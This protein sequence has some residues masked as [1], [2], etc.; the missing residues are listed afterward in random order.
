MQI[1]ILTALNEGSN[2]FNPTKSGGAEFGATKG[3]KTE[4]K[5]GILMK[6]QNWWSC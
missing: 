4:T 2:Q 6:N 1:G 5:C 3:K